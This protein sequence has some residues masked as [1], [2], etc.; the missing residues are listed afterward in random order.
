M[1]D[2]FVDLQGG[3]LTLEPE[4]SHS[5]LLSKKFWSASLTGVCVAYGLKY[6]FLGKPVVIGAVPYSLATWE[7][8]L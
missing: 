7:A 8:S 6:C 4:Q 3:Q 2:C 5:S 1:G